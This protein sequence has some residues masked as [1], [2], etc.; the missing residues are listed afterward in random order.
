MISGFQI[1]LW[2]SYHISASFSRITALLVLHHLP[3]IIFEHPLDF[4]LHG[5]GAGFTEMDADNIRHFPDLLN[6]RRGIILGVR[7]GSSGSAGGNPEE[8]ILGFVGGTVLII[9]GNTPFMTSLRNR[10]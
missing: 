9:A 5:F 3:D 4:V 6:Q 2:L 7:G 10:E 8:Q 1:F